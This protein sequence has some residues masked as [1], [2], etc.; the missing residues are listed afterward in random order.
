MITW[1]VSGIMSCAPHVSDILNEGCVDI[2]GIA[3]HWLSPHNIHFLDSIHPLYN[4]HAICDSTLYT[5]RHPIGK[6]GVCLFWKKTIDNY[7]LPID[8][9]SDR[10][11][12]I[13]YQ[14]STNQFIYI[15]QVYLPCTN[16]KNNVF[17]DCLDTLYDIYN[18]YC[19]KGLVI[20]MGDFNAKL[21]AN[22]YNTRDKR[23]MQFLNDCNLFP[24]NLLNS[25]Y[26][27]SNSY[28]SY[29][30]SCSSLIDYICMP[31]ESLDLVTHCEVAD[32]CCLN[33]SRHRPIFC[34]LNVQCTSS[35]TDIIRNCINWKKCDPIHT[36]L[37]EQSVSQNLGNINVCDMGAD[38]YY[39]ILCNTLCDSANTV[40]PMKRYR[41]FLKPYWCDELTSMHR[42]MKRARDEW[43]RAGKPRGHIHR[44]YTEYKCIKSKFRKKLRQCVNQ[45]LR[46]CDDK[47]EETSLSDSEYFW[48]IIN[49]R[50]KCSTTSNVGDGIVFNGQMYRNRDDIADQWGE[51]FKVLYSPS[52]L[53]Q[54]DE[55]WKNLVTSHVNSTFSEMRLDSTVRVESHVVSDCIKALSKGKA[56]GPDLITH[57][58]LIHCNNV[59]SKPLAELFTYMLQTGVVPDNMKK[60]N[61]ITLH[62]GGR[63]RK[64][65]PSCYRAITLSSTILKLYELIIMNQCKDKILRRINKLQGGF[66]SQ[67]G[68]IMSSFALRE[69]LHY[70][71]ECSSAVYL[72]FLDARQAFDRVWHH[73]LFYKLLSLNSNLDQKINSN[74]LIAIREMYKNS[75]CRVLYKGKYSCEFTVSQGTRQG[76]KLSPLMYLVFIDGLI[77]ELQMSD[78]GLSIYNIYFG[79]PTVADDMTLLSYSRAGMECMLKICYDYSLKWRYLYNANKCA[80][81]IFNEQKSS[82]RLP[83]YLGPDP[84]PF[85][86]GYKHLGVKCDNVLSSSESMRDACNKLRG[87]YLNICNIGID[88]EHFSAKTL[89]H[90]YSS[91]IVPKAIYGCELWNNYSKHDEN[92]LN[93]AHKFCIKHMQG[94]NKSMSTNYSLCTI[95]CTS[96]SDMIDIKKLSFFGQ[97]CRLDPK[98]LIKE[99][100]NNRLI[101]FL[102]V[103]KQTLGFIPD[104]YTLIVKYNLM[105]YLW[106]YIDNGIFPSKNQ[107]KVILQRHIVQQ[108]KNDT[109]NQLILQNVDATNIINNT[110]IS[111][112]YSPLWILAQI[113]PKLKFVCKILLR[114]IG[115]LISRPYL[116]T[117]K[118]CKLS[119]ENCIVHIMC[120]CHKKEMQRALLYEHLYR[121]IDHDTFLNFV[122]SDA[123]TQCLNLLE[124]SSNITDGHFSN[125]HLTKC[126]VNLMYR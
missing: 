101:R 99:I 123:K 38:R 119:N 26:G 86:N 124:L 93:L 100:F 109:Y 20:F 24:T 51:Y 111:E 53:P 120:Y 55:Q 41:P 92:Q 68:C 77:N 37:Y 56:C 31:V 4:Y 90:I 22:S 98:Y 71:R 126:M 67:L 89:S 13:Q 104:V 40:F 106:S 97:L 73:G 108:I 50:R 17:N 59:I 42:T 114:T 7:V 1:N 12:G 79:S 96:I 23:F 102:N 44:E 34:C 82:S 69:C 27:P 14:L 9:S 121:C 5:K 112:Q 80:T 110:I 125:Y 78:L 16:H 76:G 85:A 49:S 8:I 48:K 21:I 88:P 2:F 47:L 87:T 52:D 64:D 10:I 113:N 105:D 19:D 122:N 95:N 84:I 118:R 107:W 32:D 54:F 83:F 60:G 3:E 18:M 57:E 65:D 66:Q 6:G 70:S 63:K 15:F 33:L 117:C 25:C 74:Y 35:Y 116:N 45:Y 11:I 81:V 72:C 91:T 62:K 28:V 103:D 29:D 58:H 30:G 36:N 94:F 43:C 61:I 46:N 115:Q 75:K 39:E